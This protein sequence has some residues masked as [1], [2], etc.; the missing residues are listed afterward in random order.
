MI[1]SKRREDPQPG[2][3]QSSKIP[4]LRHCSRDLAVPL[5]KPF[6]LVFGNCNVN[7]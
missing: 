2:L 4:A 6:V 1:S 3:H 5:T 7:I